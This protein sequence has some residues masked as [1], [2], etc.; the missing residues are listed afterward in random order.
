[1]NTKERIKQSL[2]T[3]S[4]EDLEKVDQLVEGLKSKQGR[5]TGSLKTYD[6]GGKYDQVNL[7]DIAYE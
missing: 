1:M 3:L 4:K 2:D 7:R 6:L 5:R